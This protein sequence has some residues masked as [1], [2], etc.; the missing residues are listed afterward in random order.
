MA[1]VAG[2]G[3]IGTLAS[4]VVSAALGVFRAGTPGTMN[5]AP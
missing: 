3:L 5:W 4:A 2:V 1:L